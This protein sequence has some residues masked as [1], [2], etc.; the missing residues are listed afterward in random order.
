ME[1]NFFS[2]WGHWQWWSLAV[3]LVVI[4]IISPAVFFLWMGVAAGVVGALLLLFPA[5]AW[6]AQLV[7]FALISVVSIVL[8]RRY[9]DQHPLATDQPRLNRRGE[10]YVGRQFTLTEPLVNG[11]G[12]IRVD[13]TTWKISGG[14]CPVGT[15]VKVT[16]VDGVLLQ[17]EPEPVGKEDV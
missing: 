1:S 11:F 10:Q 6:E 7:A 9:L 2:D 5:L 4:E 15:Q 3:V 17:V 8:S 12:K 14:D 16:G 13:D